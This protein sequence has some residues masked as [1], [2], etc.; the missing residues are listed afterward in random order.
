MHF[1]DA[2][3]SLAQS[4]SDSM[5]VQESAVKPKGYST[6][7]VIRSSG[8]FPRLTPGANLVEIEPKE[9]NKKYTHD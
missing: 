4:I 7:I 8:G 5:L 3:G 6:C 9:A 1:L 2:A